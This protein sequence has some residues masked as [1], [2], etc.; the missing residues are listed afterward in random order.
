VNNVET[1]AWAPGIILFGGQTYERGGWRDP[2]KDPRAKMGGRR[3]FSISGD[4]AKPGVYEVAIGLPL[5]DLLEDQKYCGG[6][7]NG[8]LRA[9]ATS[10]PSGGLLPAKIPLPKDFDEKKRADAVAAI[11][12]RSAADAAFMEWWLRTKIP[13]GATHLDI[14]DIPLDL[15]F[16]RHMNGALK[17]PV[18]PML[19]AAIAVYAGNVDILDQA[20]NYTEFYRNESCGKCVPCRL[21]SQKLVQIGNELLDRRDA[22]TP[23]AGKDAEAVTKDVKDVTKTLQLTSICGLGYVAPIPLATALIYFPNDVRKKPGT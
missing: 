1:L 6:I 2:G 19:G 22:G 23:I 13:M 20:V 18:E 21:G 3:L 15:V 11:A 9:V 4:V 8:P 14:L 16:Y 12:N 17:F 10:G 5:R 7:I